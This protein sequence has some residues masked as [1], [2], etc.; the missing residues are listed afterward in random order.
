MK[1]IAM[2]CLVLSDR[3]FFSLGSLY[4]ICYISLIHTKTDIP[5]P[6]LPD[7][8]RPSR[9]NLLTLCMPSDNDA[10]SLPENF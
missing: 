3:W 6:L 8:R 4:L 9:I 1:V 2:T 10:D 7:A 5:N